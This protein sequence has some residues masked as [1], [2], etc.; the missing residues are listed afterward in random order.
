MKR[1]SGSDPLIMDAPSGVSWLLVLV[2]FLV[3][4]RRAAAGALLISFCAPVA[5]AARAAELV[6]INATGNDSG[7][8][9]SWSGTLSVEG[10][11]V[12][13]LS[14]ASDLVTKDGNGSTDVFVRDLTM[15]STSLVSVNWVGTGSGNAASGPSAYPVLSRDGPFVAF[16]SDASDLVAN[17]ANATRDVF[18]R[19]LETST[20]ELVSINAATTGSGNGGSGLLTLAM[21][22]DGRFLAFM[23]SASDLVTTDSNGEGDVF[24][25]DRLVGSTALV[26]VNAAGT[27]GGDGFSYGPSMSADGTRI[28]FASEA[29]NLVLADTNA[30]ACRDL[31]VRDLT[32][33]TTSLVTENN[34][35]PG[36]IGG[37]FAPPFDYGLSAAGRFIVFVSGNDGLVPNDANA[38]TDVFVRDLA[39]S[40]TQLISINRNGTGSGNGDS[41]NPSFSADGRFVAFISSAEDLV[42]NDTNG[43]TDVFLRDLVGET[44]SLI[45][46]NAM[47]KTSGDGSSGVFPA[48][49]N[50]EG[51][52]VAF[53]SFASDLVA[54]DDNGHLDVFVRDTRL[55][56]TH[57][58]SLNASGTSSGNGN[59]LEPW[60]SADGRLVTFVSTAS[61]LV[62]TDTNGR[63]DVF[64]SMTPAASVLA[65]PTLSGRASALFALLLAILGIFWILR[66]LPAPPPGNGSTLL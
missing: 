38:S 65:I 47:G 22:D 34:S 29:G 7:D 59:S 61:D 25:R 35:T 5:P 10:G 27:D 44:T 64:V 50:G 40:T 4:R 16:T 66:G 21:S 36:C 17:D 49:I 45:S 32:S 39:A 37:T 57:L 14:N 42:P 58:L 31:F 3:L 20:T 43:A 28:V 63:S 6:S 1:C 51:R 54:A 41:F 60:I 52:F 15:G 18:L 13:V 12:A 56:V 19:D 48:R 11:K 2:G 26:S 53:S 55:G 8:D 24:V 23:S 46:V 62:L 33:G 9:E 30:N